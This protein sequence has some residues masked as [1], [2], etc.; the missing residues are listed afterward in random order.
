MQIKLDMITAKNRTI[1]LININTQLEK[2]I[3]LPKM[4][5]L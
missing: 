2:K 1:E 3:L 4:I 5:P